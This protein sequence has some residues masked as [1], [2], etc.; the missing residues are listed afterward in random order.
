MVE[1]WGFTDHVVEIL[2]PLTAVKADYLNLTV[3]GPTGMDPHL[4]NRQGKTVPISCQGVPAEGLELR[5]VRVLA[6]PVGFDAAVQD[7]KRKDW[8][9]SSKEKI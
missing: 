1:S 8:A 7:K 9:R 4:S 6:A 5:E 3:Y 2:E